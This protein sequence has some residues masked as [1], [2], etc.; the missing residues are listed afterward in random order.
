MADW[1]LIDL[2]GARVAGV[3]RG[4][5][6][7]VVAYG[8][9]GGRS[10]AAVVDPAS[11]VSVLPLPDGGPVVCAAV[12]E[13]HEFSTADDP[14]VY[15]FGGGITGDPFQV[16]PDVDTRDLA[17]VWPVCGDED[18]QVVVLDRSGRLRVIDIAGDEPPEGVGLHVDAADPRTAGLLVGQAEAAALVAGPLRGGDS[19]P[20]EQLWIC[21]NYEGWQQVP[22]DPPLDRFTDVRSGIVAAVAG[23]RGLR[24]VV[25]DAEGSP[26]DCPEIP[27]DPRHPHVAVAETG[28]PLAVALQSSES[29]PQL[30][31][32]RGGHWAV[33]LLPPGRLKAARVTGGEHAWVVIDDRL[34]HGTG[35]WSTGS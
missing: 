24:P 25:V 2:D 18:P 13:I 32:Q 30:W 16:S 5:Y 35:L 21:D 3:E 8:D 11:T 34:W 9:R 23:H 10:F 28:H 12:S 33:E 1:T 4:H 26:L 20:G 27:L 22:V 6:A 29:G 17:R 15:V 14:P 19:K 7:T 31:H